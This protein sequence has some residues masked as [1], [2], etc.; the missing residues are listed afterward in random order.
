MAGMEMSCGRASSVTEACPRCRVVRMVRRV[1][2]L[3]AEKVASRLVEYLT[4]RLC[5]IPD[6]ER[7][8]EVAEFFCQADF[9]RQ[10]LRIRPGFQASMIHRVDRRFME[11]IGIGQQKGAS[12]LNH[13]H[14][15][16]IEN[17]AATRTLRTEHAHEATASRTQRPSY[18][19]H[20]RNAARCW[21]NLGS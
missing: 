14:L 6:E 11:C 9:R 8:Q 20:V 16:P 3:S 15:P 7:C 17:S 5:I 2:S 19:H 10:R 18:R 21:A 12:P 4:I 13:L 1:G